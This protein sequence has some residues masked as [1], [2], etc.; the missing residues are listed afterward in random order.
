[1]SDHHVKEKK[2]MRP[3]NPVDITLHALRE[4]IVQNTLDPPEIHTASH[5]FRA[6]HHP[7]LALPQPLDAIIPLFSRHVGMK[8]VDR[9][10]IVY[11]FL[12][13]LRCA[14][15]GLNEHEERKWRRGG[16]ELTESR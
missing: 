11:Q 8:D 14:L 15:A 12:V 5:N 6:N 4:I 7:R 10:T 13:Q 1:M 2:K 3:T 9:N 16:E